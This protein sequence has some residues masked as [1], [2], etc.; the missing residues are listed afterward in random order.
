MNLFRIL[1]IGLLFLTIQSCNQ[2]NK[3]KNSNNLS[4]IINSYQDHDG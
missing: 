4:E 2:F 1:T 3:Q